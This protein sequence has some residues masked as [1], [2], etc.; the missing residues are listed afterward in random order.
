MHNQP[1]QTR[2]HRGKRA[3]ESSTVSRKKPYGTPRLVV[4]GDLREITMVK[5]GS[6]GDGGGTPQTRV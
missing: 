3:P 1:K 4:Y 5:G 2:H 6:K